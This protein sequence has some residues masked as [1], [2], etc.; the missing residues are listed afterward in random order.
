MFRQFGAGEEPCAVLMVG[1][2]SEDEH[3]R[4]PA[5]DFAARYGA[6]VANETSE[7]DEA[8]ADFEPSRR[9]RPTYWDRLPWGS[10]D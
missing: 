6:S 10:R 5:S 3:I 2:R 4:Y 8:Y 1:A 9:E 7:P